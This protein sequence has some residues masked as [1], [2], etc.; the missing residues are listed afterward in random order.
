MSI[1]G[2]SYPVQ[3]H[4]L[5]EPTSDYV[6]CAVETVVAIHQE[7][8]PG[9]ILVFLTGQ[10]EV[11]S[12]VSQLNTHAERMKRSAF[13]WRLKPMPLYAG[14]PGAVQRQVFDPAPRGFRKVVVATNVAETSLTVAGVVHVV[15][16]CFVKQRAYNPIVGLEALLVAPCSQAS[17]QQRAGRAG[18]ER[19]GHVL[20]LCTSQ[21]FSA[22]L[23][24]HTVPEM[25]R[26][27]LSGMVLQLKALGIDNIM[28]FAWL[29]PP[30]AETMVRG[31]E[32]LHALGALGDDARLTSHIGVPL[33]LLPLPPMLGRALLESVKLNCSAELA[34]ICAMVSVPGLWAAAGGRHKLEAQAKFAVAEGDMVT[35]LNIYKAWVDNDRAAKWCHRHGLLPGALQRGESV[36]RQLQAMLRRLGVVLTSS[37][38]DMVPVQRALATG[39]FMN[40]AFFD[41]TEY[42]P[43]MESDAGIHVYRLVRP[44][45]RE[46]KLRVEVG[47][48]LMRVATPW[49]VFMSAAQSNSSWY[50]MSGVTAIQHEWLTEVAPHMYQKVSALSR[51]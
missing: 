26:C 9:D 28:K 50:E 46:A 6:R 4:Y 39:M 29:A 45:A 35:Y 40:A 36:L 32:T 8:L 25:Q 17:C 1:E 42:N 38:S 2:R 51:Q 3:I 49:V 11:E 14:L 31:L 18:R 24:E 47:S 30:P 20:R 22:K 7:D 43:L 37:G 15:D 41:G 34:V 12:A 19:P 44:G 16:C 48:V 13:K 23:P 21:D 10:E 27:E 33:S 5:D